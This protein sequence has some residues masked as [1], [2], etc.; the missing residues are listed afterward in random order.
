MFLFLIGCCIFDPTYSWKQLLASRARWGTYNNPV[1]M[2][3]DRFRSATTPNQRFGY[4]SQF[5]TMKLLKNCRGGDDCANRV[6]GDEFRSELVTPFIDEPSH[7]AKQKLALI[8]MDTFSPYHGMF[9]AHRAKALYGVTIIPVLSDYMKGFFQ[10]QQPPD[11]DRLMSMCMPSRHDKE[12]WLKPLHDYE[13][14]AVVCESDSGLPDAE[15]LE[16]LLN[17]TIQNGFNEARRN[18]YMMIEKIREKGIPAVRQKLCS[19][20]ED[21]HD[22]ALELG[23]EEFTDESSTSRDS[24]TSTSVVV[25]PVRGVGSEDVSLCQTMAS[26]EK[27]FRKIHGGTVFGSPREKHQSVLVQE[28]AQGQEFAIDVVSKNGQH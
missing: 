15:R 5:A 17:T 19:S 7:A 23:L 28:Y 4:A 25:K 24:F 18:K 21:A 11:F 27:A 10:I 20:V 1:V 22:F 9:L 13:L 12:S 3:N 16:A 8:V 26:V 6:A 14:V 2:S